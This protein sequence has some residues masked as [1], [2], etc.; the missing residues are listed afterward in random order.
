MFRILF[1]FITATWGCRCFIPRTQILQYSKK[2]TEMAFKFSLHI[3]QTI[4]FNSYVLYKQSCQ[5][6]KRMSHIN[7]NLMSVEWF[8]SWKDD[9]KCNGGNN[10]CSEISSTGILT[11]REFGSL[12]NSN[13]FKTDVLVTLRSDSFHIPSIHRKKIICS[14]CHAK[15]F[16]F[17]T[18]IYCPRSKKVFASTIKDYVGLN[19]TQI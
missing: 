2:N 17:Q 6:E 4:L 11:Q 13:K 12:Q 15:G 1:R 14:I 8:C 9:L 7:Y 16:K 3:V 19:T 18:F 10:N 5:C